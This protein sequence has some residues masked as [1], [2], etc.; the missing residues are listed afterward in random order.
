MTSL[1]NRATPSQRRILRIVEGAVKDAMNAHPGKQS[2]ASFAR[3]VAKRAAGTLCAQ[4]ADVLAAQPSGRSGV[5]LSAGV[6]PSGERSLDH[7]KRG[8]RQRPTRSPLSRLHKKLSIEAGQAKRV[9]QE[10][11][12]AAIVDVLRMIAGM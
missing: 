9:G 8:A 6:G 4:W 1:Y 3:S 10:E 5:S 7:Q 11:R 2:D 12:Y